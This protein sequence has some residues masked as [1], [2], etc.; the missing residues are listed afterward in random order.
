MKAIRRDPE[1]RFRSIREMQHMLRNLDAVKAVAYEPDAP[2]THRQGQQILLTTLIVI[3]ICLAIIA[4][5]LIAQIVHN[6]AH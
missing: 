2:Q 6:A 1:K 5:G 4:T 3:A